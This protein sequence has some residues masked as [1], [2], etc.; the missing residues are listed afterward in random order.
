MSHRTHVQQDL[1]DRFRLSVTNHTPTPEGLDGI[2][3]VRSAAV[4][5]IEVLVEEGERTP[6]VSEL[7]GNDP[8]VSRRWCTTDSALQEAILHVELAVM[9]ATKAIAIGAGEPTDG[10]LVDGGAR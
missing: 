4:T 8:E 10:A 6:D 2:R 7:A 1:I 3:R 5:F 9:Y